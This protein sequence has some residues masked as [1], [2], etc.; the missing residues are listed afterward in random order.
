MIK[1]I[2]SFFKCSATGTWW[3]TQNIVNLLIFFYVTE[4]IVMRPMSKYPDMIKHSVKDLSDSKCVDK[5]IV[6]I[7]NILNLMQ[8]LCKRCFHFL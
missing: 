1:Y 2:P 4:H 7:F 5:W 3:K 6:C 8:F